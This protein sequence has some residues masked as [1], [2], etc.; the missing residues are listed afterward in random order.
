MLGQA[1]KERIA[2]LHND[3]EEFTKLMVQIRSLPYDYQLTGKEAD[4]TPAYAMLELSGPSLYPFRRMLEETYFDLLALG[5]AYWELLS[6]DMSEGFQ[7]ERT[8]A[9][10]GMVAIPATHLE[11]QPNDKLF[12]IGFADPIELHPS[13]Y[14]CLNDFLSPNQAV[15]TESI[16]GL[17]E[18]ALNSILAERHVKF[19]FLTV[20]ELRKRSERQNADEMFYE[21]RWKNE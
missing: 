11:K 5:E 3:V 17:I 18:R 6:P 9:V 20:D 4:C 21:L 7:S 12:Y 10:I 2:E 13:R 8:H 15:A 14:L 1:A 16:P 19:A